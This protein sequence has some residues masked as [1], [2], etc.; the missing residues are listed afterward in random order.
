MEFLQSLKQHWIW[1]KKRR[2]ERTKA[3]SS[4]VLMVLMDL[5]I[6]DAW[7]SP[8]MSM[9]RAD[10]KA[11]EGGMSSGVSGRFIGSLETTRRDSG[12]LLLVF[13]RALLCFIYVEGFVCVSICLTFNDFLRKTSELW[14]FSRC[15]IR[16]LGIALQQENGKGRG[17]GGEGL[18]S[19]W[20]DGSTI[21]GFKSHLPYCSNNLTQVIHF[22]S[23]YSHL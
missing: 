9:S 14:K 13:K 23:Q 17:L 10:C 7:S 1:A 20:W 22:A 19:L 16:F 6:S 8:F 12:V 4:W 18:I 5:G 3:T 15:V 2:K 21:P 11:G